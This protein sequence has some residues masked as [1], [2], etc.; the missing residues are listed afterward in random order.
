M[1]VSEPLCTNSGWQCFECVVHHADHLSV[2][3]FLPLL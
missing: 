1:V 2:V 3:H